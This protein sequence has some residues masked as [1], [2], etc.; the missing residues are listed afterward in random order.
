MSLASQVAAGF[1]RV[2]TEIKSVRAA[3][4]AKPNVVILPAG[5]TT[6]DPVTTPDNSAVF[7]LDA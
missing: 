4:A 7:V 1:T 3:I 2:A 5:S 6:P